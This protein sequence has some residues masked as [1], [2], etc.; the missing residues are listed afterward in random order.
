MRSISVRLFT[1]GLLAAFSHSL[2]AQTKKHDT[3]ADEAKVRDM[4]AYLSYFLNTIGS[5]STSESDKDVL[6]TQ[7]YSKIFRDSTVQV[8]DDLDPHRS[9]PTFK[10]VQA[11]LK[12]VDF[13]FRK[14]K[15]DFTIEKITSQQNV[16]G[17]LYYR[18][19]MTRNLKGTAPD[20]TV[21]N[22]AIP[23]YIEVNYQPASQDLKIVSIYTHEFDESEM[24]KNWW[25]QLSYEWQQIFRIRLNLTDSVHLNDIRDMMALQELDLSNNRIIQN[26]QPL[27]RLTSL[28]TLDLSGT[29]I[30]DLGPVRNLTELTHL[31]LART[32]VTDISSLRYSDKIQDLDLS[33]TQV[34]DLT[35]VEKMN[36]LHQLR[37]N[38]TPIRDLSVLS[39]LHELEVLD[40]SNA[41]LSD[42]SPVASLAQL[43]ELDVAGNPITDFHILSTLTGLQTVNLDTTDIRD[44]TPLAAL[45]NLAVLYINHTHVDSL[46]VL[47]KLPQLKRIYCDHTGVTRKTA[48][49]FM[50]KRKGV[51][52]VFDSEDLRSW[53]SFLP[54]PWKEVFGRTAGTGATPSKEELVKI[55]NLDSINISDDKSILN[56]EPLKHLVSLR[57]LLAANTAVMDLSPLQNLRDLSYIDVTNTLVGSLEPLQGLKKLKVLYADG[58]RIHD[59]SPLGGLAQLDKI[60]VDRSG[61]DETNVQALLERNPACLVIYKSNQLKSWWSSLPASWQ[62]AF[63]KEGV[64]PKATSE[65]LHR[66]IELTK[67]SV[68]GSGIDD[69]T[70]LTVFLRLRSLSF[71]NTSVSDLSPLAS[72]ST[73]RSIKASASPIH[74]LHPLSQLSELEELDI[75]N[76]AV[77][78]VG[79]LTGLAQLIRLDIAGSQVRKLDPLAT[80]LNLEYLDCSNTDVRKLDPL[81]ELPLRIL[82]CYNTSVSP[83]RIDDFKSLRPKCEVVY[84]R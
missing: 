79:P 72:L 44:L 62:E 64:S 25:S 84:Y 61:V 1:I 24:L 33:N 23:R 4:V 13:F 22:N 38:G 74:D 65:D 20:G 51:L 46:S 2:Y 21:I 78:D 7:S 82:K 16:N 43:T 60:Y 81:L 57:T 54:A 9:T 67:I 32:P 47:L 41:E 29:N 77:D 11:Y 27:S 59:L 10:D 30:T 8:E 56:L 36:H 73:L 42:L 66:L 14:V 76:T 39:T 31:N 12:D 35:V 6:I 45:T 70:P 37:L 75:S 48:D 49:A 69:L 5:D 40:L 26:I 3:Q 34:S 50:A 19:Q 52:V 28:R 63:E 83:H 58:T 53:W 68:E 17:Q 18:V 80:L 71:A 15:F 55:S